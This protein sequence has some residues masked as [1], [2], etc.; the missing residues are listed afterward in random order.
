[1]SLFLSGL[2]YTYISPCL[3]KVIISALPSEWIAFE[4]LFSSL[5]G[6]IIGM[7]WQGKIRGIAIKIFIFLCIAE[8]V[9]GF[10]LGMYLC[11]I[12]FNVWVY[13]ICSLLY[14]SFIAKFVGKCTMA[15]RAKLWQDK[16]REVYDNNSSI[17][18]GIVCMVGFSSALLFMPSLKMSLF[19][20]GLC[21]IIDDLG[22]IIVYI[23]NKEIL[24]NLK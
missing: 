11:F 2:V 12:E 16:E 13:A 9:A 20:W 22:W 17:L 21:C 7:L 6:L 4:S 24:K 3:T 5:S 8:S 14:G 1:L 15:F 19:L 18:S 10:I 23:K